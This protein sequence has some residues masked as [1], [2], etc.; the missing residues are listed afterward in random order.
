MGLLR[1]STN[2]LPERQRN[3]IIRDFYGRIAHRMD[4]EPSGDEPAQIHVNARLLSGMAVV[5]GTVSALTGRRTSAMRADGSDD[6]ILTL[7][8]QDMLLR[9]DGRSESVIRAG[10]AMVTGLDRPISLV[11]PARRSRL[12]TLQFSRQEL[13]LLVPALD[14]HLSAPIALSTSALSLIRRYATGMLGKGDMSAAETKLAS[15]HLLELAALAIAPTRD[16]REQALGGGLRAARLS[17]AKALVLKRLGQPRLSAALVGK[18]LGISERYVRMLFEREE[19]SFAD[20][21]AEQRLSQAW[22]KLRD[23]A[24]SARRIVDIAYD[25]GFGDLRTFN[26]LFRKRFDCTPSEARAGMLHL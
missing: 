7:P 12:V 9:E 26:R 15:R 13:A 10:Q 2:D 1:L 4:L 8:A 19:H 21:V 14:D 17:A 11:I 23:P 6:I 20:F 22:E 18:E 3:E 5:S 25:V 16:A 24:L